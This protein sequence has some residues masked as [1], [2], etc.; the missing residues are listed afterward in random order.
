MLEWRLFI[1]FH[2]RAEGSHIGLFKEKL[3]IIK[4]NLQIEN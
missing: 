4:S 2:I 3:S 1:I